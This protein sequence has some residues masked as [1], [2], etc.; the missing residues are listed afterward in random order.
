MLQN[1]TANRIKMLPNSVIGVAEDGDAEFIQICISLLISHFMFSKIM[2]SS[3][4]FYHDTVTGNIEIH[5]IISYIFLL[6]YRN[7]QF[8][9][10]VIPKMLLFIRHIFSQLLRIGNKIFIIPIKHKITKFPL[11]P[12]TKALISLPQ[13]GRG[14]APAVDEEC[15]FPR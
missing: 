3:V 1:I 15:P 7:R 5:N 10:K 13:R 2:L 4:N 6:I 14:T 8:F 12:Q 9:Q 11:Y